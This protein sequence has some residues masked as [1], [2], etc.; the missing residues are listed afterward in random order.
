MKHP[1]TLAPAIDDFEDFLRRL[2]IW[3]VSLQPT[4]RGEDLSRLPKGLEW[5]QLN[6]GGPFGMFSFV[7][8]L[9]WCIE[10]LGTLPEFMALVDDV[11]WALKELANVG[12]PPASIRRSGRG[13]AAS[14]A[15]TP[16][17][18]KRPAEPVASKR[19]C[20]KK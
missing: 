7:I 5:K 16:R 10:A 18:T 20:V 2:R 14:L 3:W 13:G 9:S 12:E 1:P 11:T 15:A 17:G 4:E 8:S 19:K 6:I